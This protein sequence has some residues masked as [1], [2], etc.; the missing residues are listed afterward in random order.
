M[1]SMLP[2]M[3]QCA[4]QE[5]DPIWGGYLS[6]ITFCWREIRKFCDSSLAWGSAR[7]SLAP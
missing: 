1:V 4:S 3:D 5:E 6:L 7:V 2:C